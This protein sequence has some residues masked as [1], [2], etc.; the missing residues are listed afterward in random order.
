MKSLILAS[1]F[2]APL[3]FGPAAAS[4]QPTESAAESVTT[5]VTLPVGA[6]HTIILNGN[7]TT[8]YTWNAMVK[9]GDAVRV[10]TEVMAPTKAEDG[11]ILCGAPSPTKV[12][13]TAEK[14]GEAV[15]VLEYKRVW[16]TDKPAA[17]TITC[18][19]MVAAE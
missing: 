15:I 10:E 13:L 5:A 11:V 17:K 19:V 6:A 18:K 7:P 8:G 9:S 3:A 1:L 12:T 14:P 16:E 2:L 4:E